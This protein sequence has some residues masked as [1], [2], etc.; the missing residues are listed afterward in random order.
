MN[1]RR[2]K[3]HDRNKNPMKPKTPKPVAKKAV[4][5]KVQKTTSAKSG[6]ELL[7]TPM[8]VLI[9][10]DPTHS[11]ITYTID[12]KPSKSGEI[13]IERTNPSQKTQVSLSCNEGD[14]AVFLEKEKVKGAAII[15][16]VGG[17]KV[18]QAVTIETSPG[19]LKGD[20]YEYSLV[21]FTKQATI[22]ADPPLR[23]FR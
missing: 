23:I 19:A 15:F 20:E 9:G 22:C 14:L 7:N 13:N 6:S 17:A 16:R 2:N 5:K 10:L 8:N 12:G 3:T 4:A 21:V 18:G 1:V 11:H